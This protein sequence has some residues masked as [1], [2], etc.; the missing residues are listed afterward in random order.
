[1]GKR[2]GVAHR[3]DELDLLSTDELADEI[4]WAK[5]RL[6]IAP[7]AKTACQ[8]KKRIHWLEAAMTKRG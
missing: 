8:W 2:S 4:E 5:T 6:K 3:D 1:M 7:S